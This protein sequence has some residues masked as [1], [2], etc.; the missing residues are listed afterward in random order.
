VAVHRGDERFLEG[1]EAVE[2]R[3]ERGE[4]LRQVRA[5][6]LD[7]PVEVDARREDRARAGEDHRALGR[8]LLAR[9]RRVEGAQ[10]LEVERARLAVS[11]AQHGDAAPHLPLDHAGSI[12]SRRS[13]GAAGRVSSGSVH[14]PCGTPASPPRSRSRSPLPDP[15][16]RPRWPRPRA[17]SAR[18]STR[19]GARA[20]RSRSTTRAGDWH[21]VPKDR[22]GLPLGDLDAASRGRSGRC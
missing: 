7:E 6:A 20:R 12:A 13:P 3:V 1:Q 18:R 14:A 17:T 22:P 2:R 15:A 8:A 21:Y 16:R 19:A 9:E 11:Q 5:R 10:E 4:E